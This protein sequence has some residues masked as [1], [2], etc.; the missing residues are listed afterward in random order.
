MSDPYLQ[1]NGVLR[2][3]R[4]ITDWEELHAA[5]L[6]AASLREGQ[7]VVTEDVTTLGVPAEFGAAR[8]KA[9]HRHLFQDIYDWAGEYRTVGIGKGGDQ[10]F[11]IPETIESRMTDL[12][13]L[14]DRDADPAFAAGDPVDFLVELLQALNFTHPF[15]EGNARTQRLFAAQLALAHSYWLDW[16]QVTAEQNVQAFAQSVRGYRREL[17]ELIARIIEQL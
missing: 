8:V 1:P 4:G 16:E 13:A 12:T 5:E 10:Y 2:N 3:L 11:A 15:R 6:R 9:T 17:R 14:I 7:L